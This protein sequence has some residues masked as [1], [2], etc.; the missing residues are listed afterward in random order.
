VLF[1]YPVV[2]VWNRYS[3]EEFMKNSICLLG[4]VLTLGCATA[5]VRPYVGEQQSWPTA[6]G[7]IVSMKYDLP[8]FTTLPTAPYEVIA[9]LRITSPFYAQPEEHHMPLL[10]KKAIKLGADAL[11]LVD[12]GIYF[13]TQYGLKAGDT[14]AEAK[15]ASIT[16]VNRFNP[17]AFQPNVN[18]IAV[19]WQG[20]PPLGL[21]SK[22]AKYS[23]EMLKSE[24]PVPAPATTPAKKL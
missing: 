3:V 9:E 15:Q 4:L 17:E 5:V 11:L 21:P 6:S 24:P 7:S 20:T 8:V 10:V 18:V 14:G 19:R 2:V 16:E 23:K 12:G 22:Y 13:S 1:I